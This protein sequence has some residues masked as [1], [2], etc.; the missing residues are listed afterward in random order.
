[1]NNNIH[2]NYQPENINE[3]QLTI[4]VFVL[5]ALEQGWTIKKENDQYI[6][7]KKHENKKEIFKEEYLE[8]FL[9]SNFDID[10]LMK[11]T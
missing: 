7:I 10:N 1:M 8:H 4:M 5:N 2:I 9:L 6:F 11:A 3:K